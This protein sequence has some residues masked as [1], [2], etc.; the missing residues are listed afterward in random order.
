MPEHEHNGRPVA[1]LYETDRA[2]WRR[3]NEDWF[4]EQLRAAPPM[5]KA[6]RDCIAAIVGP[7]LGSAASGRMI[8]KAAA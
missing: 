6:Q 1:D 3:E 8:R 4:A 5:T 2:A 7:V